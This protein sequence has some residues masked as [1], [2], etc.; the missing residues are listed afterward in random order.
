VSFILREPGKE[1][2]SKSGDLKRIST[3]N[4]P[5]IKAALLGRTSI[6]INL[7]FEVGDKLRG[8]EVTHDELIGRKFELYSIPSAFTGGYDQWT[9][10]GDNGTMKLQ[11]YVTIKE[12]KTDDSYSFLFEDA[13]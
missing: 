7:P 11:G 12:G 10:I 6:V 2:F 5:E 3:A 9:V 4:T 8:K 13:K 1:L